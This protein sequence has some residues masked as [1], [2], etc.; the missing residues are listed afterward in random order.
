MPMSQSFKT[1]KRLAPILAPR[2]QP[3]EITM[4]GDSAQFTASSTVP[5]PALRQIPDLP[6]PPG[7]PLIGNLLQT[8]P[9]QAH[10]AFER[11]SAAYGPLFRVKFVSTTVLALSDHE[12]IGQVLRERPS[13]FRRPSIS[14]QIAEEMGGIP[15]V[16]EAEGTQWRNQR[17]MV[18]QAFAPPAIR[19]YF[20]SMLEVAGRLQRRW[21][22]AA[23]ARRTL[24]LNAELRLYSVDVIAG[25]AFGVDINTIE[26]GDNAIQRNL[27]QILPGVARRSM[28][29][30]PYWRYVKLPQDRR[31]ENAAVA[32]NVAVDQLVAQGKQR[33]RDEP[34]HAARPRNMLEAMLVAAA[35]ADSGVTEQDV[36]G[37]VRTMLL[38]GEDTTAN[39][40][41]WLVHLLHQ[42][43]DTMSKAREEVLRLAGDPAV[44]T[45]EQLDALDYLDACVHESMRLKPQAPYIPLEALHDTV[46]ADVQVPR[47]T[48]V[49]CVMRHHSVD[50]RYFPQAA[51]F[52]PERWLQD[53]VEKK[54]SM[55]F[56]AGARTCPG[57]YL[58]LL[59]IKLAMAMLLARFDVVSVRTASGAEPQERMGFAMAPERLEMVLALRS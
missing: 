55:P 50:E 36:A 24:D 2:L 37:N 56:G 4:H 21:E 7:L 54:V 48:I 5:A 43:P 49:W 44:L 26:T 23:R 38:G 47:G 34:E 28:T 42:H 18:M 41:A 16:F 1:G 40:L 13:M 10:Q 3:R 52:S 35:Q 32:V 46:I 33:L 45:I 8:K 20:P 6:C 31:L 30:F 9:D 58:A 59:E 17:K 25:L 12:L 15:G 39:A 53:N 14:A 51:S 19:A 27:D 22:Q 57:R 29:P 11:W